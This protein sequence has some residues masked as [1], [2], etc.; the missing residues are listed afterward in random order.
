MIAA[1]YKFL[2]NYESIVQIEQK[3]FETGHSKNECDSIHS[4]IQ[5]RFSKAD[6]FLPSGIPEHM[7]AA[8]NKKLY[9]VHNIV[10]T[11]RHDFGKLNTDIMKTTAF[12]GIQ[13]IHHITHKNEEGNV[14][15]YFSEEN[16][17]DPQLRPFLKLGYKQT[18]LSKAKL[19]LAYD[20]PC[21]IDSDK[22][23]DL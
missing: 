18:A 5:N 13:K 9:K 15:L 20:K 10:H 2:S 4:A 21:A 23:N 7:K 8:H 12:A 3:Y 22:N 14:S 11:D 1:I 17:G 19:S 6:V 16:R